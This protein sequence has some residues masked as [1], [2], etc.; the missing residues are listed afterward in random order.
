MSLSTTFA[1]DAIVINLNQSMK[2]KSKFECA[3]L[4]LNASGVE[5]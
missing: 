2:A 3:H 5:I 1:M 4:S